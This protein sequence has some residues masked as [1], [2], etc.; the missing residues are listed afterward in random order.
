M[1]FHDYPHLRI[2]VIK[3][4]EPYVEAV[5]YISYS[6]RANNWTGEEDKSVLH[7]NM[8]KSLA[9]AISYD[10]LSIN[11]DIVIDHNDLINDRAAESVVKEI[12]SE[13]GAVVDPITANSIKVPA[14]QTNDF[15]VGA[16]GY[17][18]NTPYKKGEK[19]ETGNSRYISLFKSKLR[20]AYCRDYEPVVS[21]NRRKP[22][23]SLVAKKRAASSKPTSC[24]LPTGCI[25]C[26]TNKSTREF[27]YLRTVEG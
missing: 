9:E 16:I 10:Y 21:K 26:R 13:S 27:R 7:L 18:Y 8:L 3:Q 25:T 20:Q 14:L 17:F 5:Y 11:F 19:G 24:G 23:P 12:F 2:P 15:F 22:A 6:K 1:K 4:A